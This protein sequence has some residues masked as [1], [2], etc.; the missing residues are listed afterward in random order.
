MKKIIMLL[1]VVVLTYMLT[2]CGK[3]TLTCTSTQ[4]Q[5]GMTMNTEVVA[6]FNN[7]EVTNMDLNIVFD[8]DDSYEDYIETI[9][10]SIDSQY[11]KYRKKGVTVNVTVEDKK[12]NAKLVFDLKKMSNADKKDLDIVDVYGTKP[13]TAKDLEKQGYTCK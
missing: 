7:N 2:G 10:E 1:F 9:R 5:T 8:V 3:E 4:K 12:I 11:D 6:L 13:A